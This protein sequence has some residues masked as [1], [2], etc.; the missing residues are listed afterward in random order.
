MAE[1]AIFTGTATSELA[2]DIAKHLSVSLGEAIVS[3]FSDGETRVE[4]KE[5]V[6]GR[7][8]FVVQSTCPPTN[9]HL[10]ELLIIVDALRRSSAGRITAVIPYYGYARQDRRPRSARVPI[11]AKLAAEMIMAA[12]VDRIVTVDIHAEQIQGFFRIPMDNV[13]GT[14]ILFEKFDR[15]KVNETIVVSPDVGGVARARAVAK[16]LGCDLAIIDKRR[17]NANEA[18]V[19]HV[20]GEVAD[21]H[22]ILVDDIVDTAGTLCKAADALKAR[23]AKKI[24]AYCVHPILSGKAVENIC[25]SALEELVVTDSI[26]LHEQARNCERIKQITLAPMLAETIRRLRSEESLHEMFGDSI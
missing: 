8:V 10:M 26:P 4:I 25:N 11:T 18:Q 13:Y 2:G 7:D 17:P 20:I 14:P 5:N 16:N 22:C 15:S 6:R 12:G 9:D 1:L 21:R 24:S 3:K 19:M 23:G